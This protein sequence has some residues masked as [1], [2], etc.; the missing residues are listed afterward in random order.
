VL[1]NET[2]IWLMRRPTML[3]VALTVLTT[4]EEQKRANSM[5][6]M[7]RQCEWLAGRALLRQCLAYYT[8]RD[9]LTLVFDKT[10]SGKPVL[11]IHDAPAFNLS[12]G[13]R[14]IACAVAQAENVGIDVD[15]EARRNRTDEIAARYFHPL[16]QEELA[17]AGSELARKRVFFRQ[18]TMKEAYIKAIGETIN[19]VRLHE[20]AFESL[21]GSAPQALFGLPKNDWQFMHRRFD[22]D[23]HLALACHRPQCDTVTNNQASCRYWLWDA[24]TQSRHELMDEQLCTL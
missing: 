12:H 20:L 10:V 7:R 14:W 9:G 2:H 4:A 3:D 21:E 18:W 1:L 22:G 13:P 19:S 24:A 16:E 17:Q 23:H 6:S 15:S 5:M 11:D 8:G